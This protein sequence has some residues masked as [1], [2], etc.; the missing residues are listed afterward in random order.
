MGGFG[1]CAEREGFYGGEENCVFGIEFLR[2]ED[3]G[4]EEE[5]GEEGWVESGEIHFDV[6]VAIEVSEGCL[7][8]DMRREDWGRLVHIYELR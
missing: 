3:G 7:C 4:S 1:V 8:C 2:C 5:E 6:R